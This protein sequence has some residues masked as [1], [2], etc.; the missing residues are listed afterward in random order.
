MS[1]SAREA[2]RTYIVR[3]EE[4][5]RVKTFREELIEFLEK[6]GVP[7]DPRYLD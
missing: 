1:A 2:V 4:H 7:Y 3:Q 6:S 5:H